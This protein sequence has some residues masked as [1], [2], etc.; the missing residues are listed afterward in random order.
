MREEGERRK[1][2]REEKGRLISHGGKASQIPTG[3][4]L[5]ENRS[6]HLKD[7]SKGHASTSEKEVTVET[8]S[9]DSRGGQ[10]SARAVLA[11]F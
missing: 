1:E 9:P 2:L 11:R 7:M 5:T 6:D 8:S 10:K 3:V 4:S